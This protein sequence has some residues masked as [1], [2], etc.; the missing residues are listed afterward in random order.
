MAEVR[1]ARDSTPSSTRYA[2]AVSGADLGTELRVPAHLPQRLGLIAGLDPGPQPLPGDLAGPVV[3]GVKSGVVSCLKAGRPDRDEGEVHEVQQRLRTGSGLVLRSQLTG[4]NQKLLDLGVVGRLL[5]LGQLEFR[6]G[7]RLGGGQSLLDH[8][9]GLDTE[10]Q[11][12]LGMAE[13]CLLL[14]PIARPLE[15]RQHGLP[16]LDDHLLAKLDRLGQDDLFLGGQERGPTDLVEVDPD[17]VVHADGVGGDG[18]DFG[19]SWLFELLGIQNRWPIQDNLA[20]RRRRRVRPAFAH[21][22]LTQIQRQGSIDH[23]SS[24]IFHIAPPPL[25]QRLRSPNTGRT[26][27]WHGRGPTFRD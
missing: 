18:L 25:A 5:R 22:L 9:L 4:A 2:A 19:G 27:T 14:G 1:W 7:R 15:E 8:P 13:P 24:Y 11:P 26:G 17:G 3:Q 20:C 16:R 12:V 6:Q 21:R 23:R 10:G